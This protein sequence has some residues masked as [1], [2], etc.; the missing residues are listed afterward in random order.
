MHSYKQHN[1]FMQLETW[2]SGSEVQLIEGEE[3]VLTNNSITPK[4]N[5]YTYMRAHLITE[6][7]YILTGIWKIS[8]L[9]INYQCK[10]ERVIVML[11]HY[12]LHMFM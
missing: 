11:K 9:Y 2:E 4:I 8:L 1:S 7:T 10:G 12:W 5:N 6:F 3:L